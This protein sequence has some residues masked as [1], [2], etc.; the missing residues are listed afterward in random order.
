MFYDSTGEY[1]TTVSTV[2]MEEFQQLPWKL[3]IIKRSST[4]NPSITV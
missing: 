3:T 2:K 1:S 4:V